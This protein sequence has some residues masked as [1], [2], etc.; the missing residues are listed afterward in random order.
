M[1]RQLVMVHL[2]LAACGPVEWDSSHTGPGDDPSGGAL[3]GDGGADLDPGPPGCGGEL[4]PCPDAGAQEAGGD[5]VAP[6][7]CAPSDGRTYG[8]PCTGSAPSCFL[9]FLGQT[10]YW[11]PAAEGVLTMCARRSDYCD[12]PDT[13]PQ[14]PTRTTP[15]EDGMLAIGCGDLCGCGRQF[16]HTWIEHHISGTAAGGTNDPEG[17]RPG[18][19]PENDDMCWTGIVLSGSGSYDEVQRS[20]D[21]PPGHLSV[22][23]TFEGAWA[24][25]GS[26]TQECRAEIDILP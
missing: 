24:D 2:L 16:R 23:V 10:Y 26:W 22:S 5:D 21:F 3:T 15:F 1:R 12:E 20:C 9:S 13:D 19:D 7:D 8:M 18:D 14:C 4:G 17:S 6:V 25:G 11:D